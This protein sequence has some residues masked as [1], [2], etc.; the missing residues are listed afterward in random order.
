MRKR[1]C[2]LGWPPGHL[3]ESVAYRDLV[4]L[5]WRAHARCL[6]C[7]RTRPLSVGER[8]RPASFPGN[9]LATLLAFG[10]RPAEAPAPIEHVEPRGSMLIEVPDTGE[11]LEIRAALVAWGRWRGRTV[12]CAR[13]L[14][15]GP[16]HTASLDLRTAIARAVDIRGRTPWID[17]LARQLE[18][19]LAP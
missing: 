19:E 17:E 11:P 12:Y 14:G 2:L 16:H 9:P 18:H 8:H 3:Y 7:G 5:R 1:T 13:R 10:S 15:K 4:S 6:R